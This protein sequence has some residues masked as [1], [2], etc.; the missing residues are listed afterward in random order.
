MGLAD[1]DHRPFAFVSWPRYSGVIQ[2]ARVERVRP[3]VLHEHRRRGETEEFDV[4][5]EL[6]YIGFAMRDM[7]PGSAGPRVLSGLRRP[8]AASQIG[9]RIFDFAAALPTAHRSREVL[10]EDQGLSNSARSEDPT[11]PGRAAP[12]EHVKQLRH[13]DT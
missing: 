5:A 2:R 12:V 13:H 11:L 8:A 1:I 10:C 3:N 9:Q 7:S 4:V 6:T